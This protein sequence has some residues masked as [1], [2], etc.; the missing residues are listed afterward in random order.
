V[1]EEFPAVMTM[2]LP[3][4]STRALLT[5]QAISRRPAW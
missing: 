2:A 3:F 5:A 1:I 4:G